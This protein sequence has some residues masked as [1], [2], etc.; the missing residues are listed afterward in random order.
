MAYIMFDS[1]DVAELPKHANALG[2]Y[3]GGNWPTYEAVRRGWPHA[4]VLSIAVN[5]SEHR[6]AD[7]TPVE[8]LDIEP[9]DATPEQAVAWYHVARSLGVKRPCFYGSLSWVPQIEGALRSTGIARHEYRIWSAHYTGQAHIC[10]K[11]CGL[12]VSADATQFTDHALGR[13]LDESL[14]NA[15]FFTP[16]PSRP[17]LKALTRRERHDVELYDRLAQHP[18]LHPVGLRKVQKRLV[19]YRKAIYRAAQ[20]EIQHG[21]PKGSAWRFRN[22]GARYA[23][24]WSRT[25]GLK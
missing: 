8:C 20:A 21:R 25:R 18:R 2:A 4:H 13:N 17:T 10:G 23:I 1:V 5:A 15:A 9:G 12:S 22:R 19:G 24:L 11:A 6:C 14:C 3:A 7:G 16:S